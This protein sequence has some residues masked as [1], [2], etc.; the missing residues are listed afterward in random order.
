MIGKRYWAIL[1]LLIVI[2]SSCMKDDDSEYVSPQE[3]LELDIV[4]IEEYLEENEIDAIEHESGIYYVVHEEGDA[5]GD[6]ITDNSYITFK[7]EGRYL[8]NGSVFDSSESYRYVL[9][10]L[11]TGFRIIIPLVKKGANVTMYI[12]RGY[13]YGSAILIF[14]VEILEVE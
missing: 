3:Q 2:T 7:Y 9:S 14:D 1:C 6:T 8:T 12:P 11:I 10:G 13:A 5:A 4:T